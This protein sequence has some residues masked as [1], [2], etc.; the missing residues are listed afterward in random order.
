MPTFLV[1]SQHSP[2]SCWMFNEKTRQIHLNLANKLESLLK[3]HNITLVGCW[4]DLPGHTLYEF[5]DAPDFDTFQKLAM[6]PEIVQWS[7]FNTMKI[8]MVTSVNDVMGMLQQ[9]MKQI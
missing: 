7:S 6:E 1:I 3:K 8:K 4:F 5:Y 2:E 9:P